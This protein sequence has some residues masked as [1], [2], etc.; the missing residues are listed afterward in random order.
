MAGDYPTF[1]TPGEDEGGTVRRLWKGGSSLA[2]LARWAPMG[3]V[4]NFRNFSS[5]F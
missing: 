1:S 4:I 2:H 5:P 3:K